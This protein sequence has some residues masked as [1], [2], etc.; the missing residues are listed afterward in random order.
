VVPT[1]P[2]EPKMGVIPPPNGNTH[3]PPKGRVIKTCEPIRVL[4]KKKFPG[5]ES[6]PK[7]PKYWFPP[8]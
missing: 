6:F 8:N 7:E 2:R 5:M 3:V 4:E 1:T